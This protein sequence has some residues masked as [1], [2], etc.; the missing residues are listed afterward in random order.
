M[1]EYLVPLSI[2]ILGLCLV[3]CTIVIVQSQRYEYKI[4]EES[5]HPSRIDKATGNLETYSHSGKW[6]SR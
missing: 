2:L 6:E 4:S 1:K 5:F 3:I